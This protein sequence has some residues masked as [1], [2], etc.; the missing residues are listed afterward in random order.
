[1][2]TNLCPHSG[3]EHWYPAVDGT[4][5]YGYSYHFDIMAKSEGFGDNPLVNFEQVNCPGTASSD[6][7]QRVCWA[8]IALA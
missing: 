1:M 7:K 5:N 2:V 8:D 4:N 3:N 6:Y